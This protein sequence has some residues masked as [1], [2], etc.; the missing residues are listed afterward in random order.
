[1]GRCVLRSN[2]SLATGMWG[3][4]KPC[5]RLAKHSSE[6]SGWPRSQDSKRRS[7]HSSCTLGLRHLLQAP[8]KL[9]WI[10]LPQAQSESGGWRGCSGAVTQTLGECPCAMVGLVLG[11]LARRY[12]RAESSDAFL[13]PAQLRILYSQDVQKEAITFMRPE[14]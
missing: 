2:G 12:L 8:Q 5:T 4:S 14:I 3:D 1:M 9:K 6:T 10:R 7:C 13:G 11:T